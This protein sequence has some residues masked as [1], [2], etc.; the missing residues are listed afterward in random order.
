MNTVPYPWASHDAGTLPWLAVAGYLVATL[1]CAWQAS[2]SKLGSERLFW[3]F[4]ALAMLALGINKQLDLQT[5]LTAFGRQW[6][7]NGGW[8][9]QRREFQA[10]F[11]RGIVFAGAAVLVLLG[12]LVR[13]L[14]LGVWVALLGLALLGTFVAVRAASFHHVDI[15]MR[16]PV[17][18]L[19][20]HAVLEL[21]GIAV[22]M[23]GAALPRPKPRPC[24]RP[25]YP[26]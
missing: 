12:W 14:R 13:N 26:A 2:R 24:R 9:E 5:Q 19:K 20:L 10:L 1:L 22:V 25:G 11:I 18:G 8:Y 16:T 17:I 3:I 15:M 6:A 7:R 21:A 4:A 23:L